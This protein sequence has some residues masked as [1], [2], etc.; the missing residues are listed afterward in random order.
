MA[1][2]AGA[3]VFRA[4]RAALG[5]ETLHSNASAAERTGPLPPPHPM[6][7]ADLAPECH[8]LCRGYQRACLVAVSD[9]S[10]DQSETS[11]AFVAIPFRPHRLHSVC[12]GSLSNSAAPESDPAAV[13]A[14]TMTIRS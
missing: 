12:L 11:D 4:A 3:R 10:D 1:M 13:S 5:S 9:S 7:P 6:T 2:S 14:C 8:G